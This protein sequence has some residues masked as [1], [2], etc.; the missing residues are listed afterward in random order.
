MES[1]FVVSRE[2]RRGEKY[3]GKK[4]TQKF[5][6]YFYFILYFILFYILCY[7]LYFIFYIKLEI[8]LPRQGHARPLAHPPQEGLQD[9]Q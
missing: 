6:F 8:Y 5:Y 4:L 1:G 2:P 3:I 7:I 9:A